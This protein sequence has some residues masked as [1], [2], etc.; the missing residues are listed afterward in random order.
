MGGQART[1][2]DCVRGGL[3]VSEL[4]GDGETN[5]ERPGMGGAPKGR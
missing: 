3:V 1:I 2:L 4:F 5:G